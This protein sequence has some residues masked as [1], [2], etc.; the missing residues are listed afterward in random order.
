MPPIDESL[1]HLDDALDAT[2]ASVPDEEMSAEP[3]DDES[4]DL[5]DDA[6]ET[7]EHGAEEPEDDDEDDD[8]AA[9]L[10]RRNVELEERL[11]QHDYEQ[12]QAANQRYWDDLETQA[13]NAFEYE[14]RKIWAEKDNYVDPDAYLQTELTTLQRR[15]TDWFQRFYASQNQ[16]R[17]QQYE[18][19]TIPAYAARLATQHGL[20][21]TDAQELLE[22][23]VEQMPKI[24]KLLARAAQKESARKRQRQQTQRATAR[25]T[26]PRLKVP[27][28]GGGRSTSKGT[29][30]GSLNHLKEIFAGA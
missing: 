17:A 29:K 18:R 26:D 10:R 27:A 21:N 8:D 23:P 7:D 3:E 24:A 4:D 5:D 9:A 14:E 13:R 22:Y 30:A 19:A 20:S 6:L 1:P 15:V 16:A 12:Q 11:R 2:D 28:P 25:A